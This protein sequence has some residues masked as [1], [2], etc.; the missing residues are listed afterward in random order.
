MAVPMCLPSL[1]PMAGGLKLGPEM[2]RASLQESLMSVG[3]GSRRSSFQD[4]PAEASLPSGKPVLR[5]L[6]LTTE[7]D[8]ENPGK[9][10]ES[11]LLTQLAKLQTRLAELKLCRLAAAE[12]I[13]R[14]SRRELSEI[15]QLARSPPEAVRRTLAATWLLLHA[16]R[17]KGRA[18]SAVKFDEAKDWMRVKRMLADEAFIDKILEFDFAGLSQVRHV[19]LYV[20]SHYLGLGELAGAQNDTIVL[21]GD[22]KLATVRLQR[23]ESRP[24]AKVHKAP[25][26]VRAV[27]RASEPCGALLI[28]IHRLLQ[29]LLERDKLEAELKPCEEQLRIL[30]HRSEALQTQR[31]RSPR[32]TSPIMVLRTPRRLEPIHVPVAKVMLKEAVETPAKLLASPTWRIELDVTGRLASVRQQLSKCRVSFPKNEQGLDTSCPALSKVASILKEHRGRLK[33]RLLGHNEWGEM[34]LVDL[35]RGEAVLRW[36]T[37]NSGIAFGLLRTEGAGLGDGCGGRCVV[38]VPIQELVPL[39]GPI[40]QEVASNSAPVGLYFEAGSHIPGPE[41]SAILAEMAAWLRRETCAEAVIEGHTD[42]AEPYDLS[43]RRAEA[44]R[45]VLIRLGVSAK[46]LVMLPQGK[47]YPLSRIHAAPNRR[48][49]LHLQGSF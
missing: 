6:R 23:T 13:G 40:S 17:F 37:D 22:S 47:A 15:K 19:A 30:T 26:E 34:E 4:F 32:P 43:S 20:A 1:P 33:L 42:H 48:A 49:E 29:E 35:Q 8:T 38:P 39:Y 5:S 21:H 36:L 45:E 11:A 2:R 24:M 44:V 14:L 9:A 18:P 7:E 25:L 28:W 31:R 12:Q 10:Q 16:E 46:R 27:T 3:G 41:A